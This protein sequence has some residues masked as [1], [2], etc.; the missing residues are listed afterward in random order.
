M[1]LGITSTIPSEIILAAGHSLLD[2]NNAFVASGDPR[3]LVHHA[4]EQGFPATCCGWIKGMY[5]A[6]RE[7]VQVDGIVA[8]TGGDCSNTLALAQ[9]FESEGV[10]IYSFSY[11]AERDAKLLRDEMA[12]FAELLGTDL[13]EAQ[14]VRKMLRPVR[15]GLQKLD[16]ALA[17]GRL[18]F[19][20]YHEI[21]LDSSDFGGDVEK[22][23]TRV[24]ELV[25]RSERAQPRTD[26]VPIALLGVPPIITDLPELFEKFGLRVVLDEIPRQFTMP[27][28]QGSLEQQYLAYSYPYGMNFRVQDIG[29][30][31]AKRGVKAVVHYTQTFCFRAIEDIVLRRELELPILTVE[32]D[33]PRAADARLRLRLESYSEMLHGV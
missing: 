16:N 25:E 19:A 17:E 4:H 14:K 29:R 10:K 31:C 22:Y 5:S 33:E 28:W 3:T 18:S 13:V 1:K 30:Q 12:R 11:P 6:V 8:V 23:S 26:G 15:E 24:F 9:T 20:D 27:H 32:G 21:A 2:L 7:L